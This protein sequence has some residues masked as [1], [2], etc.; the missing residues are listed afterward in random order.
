MNSACKYHPIFMYLLE[1]TNYLDN[2]PQKHSSWFHLNFKV[3]NQLCNQQQLEEEI[4][5]FLQESLFQLSSEKSCRT[6]I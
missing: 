4:P 1:E 5:E 6:G 3:Q 2:F